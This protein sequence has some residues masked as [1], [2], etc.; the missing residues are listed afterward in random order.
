[1]SIGERITEL[2]KSNNL[3]QVELAKLMEVSRQAVSKW[4]NDTSSPDSLKLIKLADV[5]STEVEYLVT[6]VHPVYESP[7]IIVNLVKKS[8]PIPEKIVEKIIEVPVEKQVI[9]RVVRTKYR[10]DPF[11][12]TIIGICAFV[13]G[14]II[15]LLF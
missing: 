2:R 14:L 7:P 1:M 6:G 3:S 15:G 4:E 12:G 13:L 9:R 11:A 5:L 8:D 10:L